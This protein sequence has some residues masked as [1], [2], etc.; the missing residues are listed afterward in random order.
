MLAHVERSHR[1]ALEVLQ[2]GLDAADGPL[3]KAALD[4][5]L[6][7]RARLLECDRWLHTA[8]QV[9]RFAKR[10][11]GPMQPRWTLDRDALERWLDEPGVA[12]SLLWFDDPGP[13]WLRKRLSVDSQGIS[14]LEALASIA[15]SAANEEL[16]ARATMLE[17]FANEWLR[18]DDSTSP[19]DP[20]RPQEPWWTEAV[21]DTDDRETIARKYIAALRS[22]SSPAVFCT[23]LFDRV[24]TDAQR[25]ALAAQLC[26]L[27]AMNAGITLRARAPIYG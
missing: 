23:T 2:R 9:A 19:A 8:T 27:I 12:E 3:T 7:P 26:A 17:E 24:A 18:G 4:H 22:G 6:N 13:S 14:R 21:T 15:K 5:A 25:E 1:A 10:A 20:S 16:T 11:K